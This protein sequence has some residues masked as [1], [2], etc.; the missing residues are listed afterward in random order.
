MKKVIFIVMIFS[1]LFYTKTYAQDD[2]VKS[3]IKKEIKTT[4]VV[5]GDTTFIVTDTIEVITER[6]KTPKIKKVREA[7]PKT[8][9]DKEPKEKEFIVKNP[10]EKKVKEPKIKK[11]EEKKLL[12]Y[13]IPKG[14]IIDKD[15]QPRFQDRQ[16]MLIYDVILSKEKKSRKDI[17]WILKNF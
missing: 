13:K 10:K 14:L 11:V 2:K 16:N 7:K 1:F 4:K 12:S 8:P 17:N 3:K 9:K 15:R 5:R 6:V